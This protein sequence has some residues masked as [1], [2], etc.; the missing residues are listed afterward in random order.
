M[1]F[2]GL[3]VWWHME[4]LYYATA[5]IGW[6]IMHNALI[7]IVCLSVCPSVMCLIL[8]RERKGVVN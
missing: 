8:S 4:V 2:I 6:G 7:A 3:N 5:P 1:G